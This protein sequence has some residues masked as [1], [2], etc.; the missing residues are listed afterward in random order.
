M[1][2]IIGVLL[3]FLITFS[4]FAKDVPP[5]VTKTDYGFEIA[6]GDAK[7]KFKLNEFNEDD[8]QRGGNTIVVFHSSDNTFSADALVDLLLSAF[9]NKKPDDNNYYGLRYLYLDQK[10]FSR[11]QTLNGINYDRIEIVPVHRLINDIDVNLKG[12]SMIITSQSITELESNFHKLLLN[13]YAVNEK[14]KQFEEL[15]ASKDIYKNE[16]FAYLMNNSGNLTIVAYLGNTTDSLEIPKEIDG[17]P[18]NVIYSVQ[19]LTDSKF[20]IVSI[21]KTITLICEDAF[22]NLGIE[23]LISK[24]ELKFHL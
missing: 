16:S 10:G 1:K 22:S 21:P 13:K 23:K 18:V 9:P 17:I 12:K 6:N 3:G 19:S 15:L 20:K 24:K 7:S 8:L 14:R 2:R 11:L 4:V 5:T